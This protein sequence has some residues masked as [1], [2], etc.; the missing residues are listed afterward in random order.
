MFTAPAVAHPLKK[1][2]MR[3]RR[4]VVVDIENVAGGAVMTREMAEWARAVVETAVC[5]VDGE[6]VVI[7]TSH[8]G[9]FNA[10]DTWRCARVEARSGE[11]GADLE[12]LDI[13]TTERVEE[14]F[15]EVV[16]VSGDGLFADVVA[17]LGR[18]GVKVTVASWSTSM[19]ARLRLAAGRVVYMDGWNARDTRE[20]IA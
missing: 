6:Q 18:C 20:A 11:N 14:R 5:V 19:S 9:L 2:A 12:L 13:L 4:Y 1:R 7:G 10:K 3:G 15:D 16:L 17:H 8:A